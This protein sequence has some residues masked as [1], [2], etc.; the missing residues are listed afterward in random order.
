M[1]FLLL[2]QISHV[3]RQGSCISGCTVS[4][5][6]QKLLSCHAR[7]VHSSKGAFPDE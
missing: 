1:R 2:V 5:C 4:Q 3:T 7:E 6:S